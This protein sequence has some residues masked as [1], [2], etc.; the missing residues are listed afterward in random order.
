MVGHTVKWAAAPL[1]RRP[2]ASYSGQVRRI[3][4]AF[5]VVASL[6]CLPIACA[7]EKPGTLEPL[8]VLFLGDNGPHRPHDRFR[9]IRPILARRQ[10]EVV[11]TDRIEDLHVDI[12]RNFDGLMLYANIDEIDPT[13][14]KIVLDYVESGRGFIPI[15]CASYCFRNNEAM[16][17][18]I[19]AQFASH[20]T[21]VFRV[22]PSPEQSQHP[23][24]AGYGGMR[25]WDETYVHTLHNEHDRTVLEY[26]IDPQTEAREPWTW[27]RTQGAG[28]VFY[29]AWGHD[30][31]TWSQP[32]FQNLLERGIR[33][34]CGAD[35]AQ[36][37]PF[38]DAPAMSVPNSSASPF[39]YVAADVPFYPPGKSWGTIEPGERRMQLPVSPDESMRHIV[40]PEGFR[41]ALVVSEPMLQGKPIAMTWDDRGRLW[42]CE[43]TD[44]PNELKDNTSGKDRVRICEDRDGD[45]RIDHT[46][47]FADGLSIPTS[48]TFYD[49]GAIVQSGKETL[50]LKDTDG[51]GKADLRRVLISGW[52]MSDTHGGVSNFQYGLDG[53]YYAMQGYNDSHPQLTD[54]EACTPFRMGFFRFRVGG[55]DMSV[56]IT[57]LE[58]LRST[59][60]NTWGLGITEE[61]LIFGSTANGNPSE[62]MAVP[63][64][65]YEAVRGWS[66]T[67]LDG[68]ADDYF[69]SPLDPDK[70]R[71]VDWHGGF[72]AG[73]GH[74]IYTARV[75]PREYWNRTAFVAEPTGH[76]VA[77]F[78]L[79]PDGSQFRSQN[80]WNLFASDDEW[81]APIMAE[82]G[83]D[84]N[85]WVLDWYN[86][87]V[88]H[89]PTPEGY[90]TGKGNAYESKLRDK[91]YG[92][93]YRLAYEES[94]QEFAYLDLA[95]ASEAARIEALSHT[96]FF[97]RRH[98][99]RL[100]LE[101]GIL[102]SDGISRL[103]SLIR[104]VEVDDVGLSPAAQHAIWI[105][106]LSDRNT[107]RTP[108]ADNNLGMTRALWEAALKHPSAGVRRNAVQA[109][110]REESYV[111]LL[112]SA[113]VFHDRDDQVR[114]AA[115]LA[116][117]EAPAVDFAASEIFSAWNETR[118]GDRWIRD[119]LIA[120]AARNAISFLEESLKPCGEERA[121][122]LATILY[123]VA[124][125]FSI[126]ANPSETQRLIRAFASANQK[127]SEKQVTNLLD[128]LL[129]GRCV[130]TKP[131]PQAIAEG[132]RFFSNLTTPENRSKWLTWTRPWQIPDWEAVVSTVASEL[133][134]RVQNRSLED[135]VRL[136]AAE[137][138]LRL[139]VN[140]QDVLRSVLQG[141]SVQDSPEFS[142]GVIEAVG[143]Q[144]SHPAAAALMEIGPKT[145]PAVRNVIVQNLL[146]RPD[147]ASALLDAVERGEFSFSDLSLEQRQQLA[148]HPQAG[149]ASR[150]SKLLEQGGGT[151]NPDRQ[152]VLDQMAPVFASRGDTGSGKVVFEKS[153][154]KCHRFDSLGVA[155][156]PD[157]TGMSAHPKA[158]LAIH[159]LDPN[160]SVEGN[161]RVF[162]VHMHDGRI[163][164]GMLAA[165]TQT[166]LELVDVD[167]KRHVLQRA[168]IEELTPSSKSIMPEGFEQQHTPEELNNLLEFLI[169][170]P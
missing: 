149:I 23:V 4:A 71:Q 16:V 124:R 57:D 80:A 19:G 130:D 41:P 66:A 141:I 155:I 3:V 72:T 100:L 8:R 52:D 156:G 158:E 46:L 122:S 94:P 50:Y 55:H 102:S 62:F 160:R 109:L 1:G 96:N 25:S 164:S 132:G 88:Q 58:F 54:G 36:V 81:S 13:R 128:G 134:V 76:L 77:T 89:N 84:G 18:L 168:E 151:P 133:V 53:W 38:V 115:F 103:Q 34:S 119:A 14:A 146:R 139:Q 63:N 113:N 28:R 44:Y 11:Y 147:W 143:R 159:M 74:C 68:I 110:P 73:A 30:G 70:I 61:G 48:V 140:D 121:D 87:I 150:A 43:T 101:Q 91:S 67:A 137:N 138:L 114:L 79:R 27:V 22:A 21:G 145:T 118:E 116:L 120:A 136:S 75:Y 60:N 86:Y 10:I 5:F 97:W 99:Q 85:V 111:R 135:P 117:A 64:R 7:D 17:K 153:C 95:Q 6:A 163:L 65:F 108:S 49:R 105:L 154:A 15:H 144:G 157:L 98:A 106:A 51:D 170:R 142:F 59:N 93:I 69:F 165:E 20:G 112:H 167:A 26:R 161:F 35:P 131:E 33:W 162:V 126:E 47:I 125:H 152:R 127:D 83:P 45:G 9:L 123:I 42:V 90:T 31:R 166:S 40:T 129:E 24:V 39:E 37:P 82:V 169:Q 104:Q 32:G 148:H 92:R 29:T 107:N 78:R 12:L 2:S 56:A